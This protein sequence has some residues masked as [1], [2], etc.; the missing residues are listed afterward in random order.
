MLLVR[1]RNGY[2]ASVF[3]PNITLDLTAPTATLRA[4]Y[5]AFS[6]NNDGSQDEM[7]FTQTGSDEAIWL[8]EVRRAG[9][10]NEAVR[11]IRMSGQPPARFSWDGLTDSGAIAP[12]G[13]YTYQLSAT[14]QAGNTG[15]SAAIAFSLSTADTPVLLTTDSRAFSP[16]GDGVKDS[17]AIIPQLQ[18]NRDI[19]SWKV[20]VLDSAGNSVRTFE[21]QNSVPASLAW[22]GRTNTNTAA[23]DGTYTA[24]I[25][26]R[27]AAGN[28]PSASSRP[29]VLDTA[30]PR[31]EL[32][33]PYTLFSPNGDGK[34]DTLPINLVTE[35][36]D[37]WDAV[38]TDAQGR[39]VQSRNWT[40]AAPALSWDG[41]DQAGN[42]VPDGIYRLTLSS[43]DEAGNS[44]RKTID[45]ITVDARIPR[46]FLTVSAAGISPK[47]D[48]NIR[49][50][51]VVSLKEG[52][53]SW[54]LELTDDAGAVFRTL[55][56]SAASPDAPPET[57][58]W[59]GLDAAGRIVEGRYTPVL[60]V[61]YTKGDEVTASAAPV[62]VD[63]SGPVLSFRSEP[64]F[65]SPD[66]DGVDDELYMFLG[67]QDVSPI[68]SWSL[69]IR[70]PEPPY[71]L[72][73]RIEGRGAPT[74]RAIWDGRSSR[75]ELV[76]SATDYPFTLQAEDA[77]G[78]S[79]TLEGSIGVDVLVIRD[80]D[81]LKIQI[82]SIVFR[83]NQADFMGR[84]R[85]PVQGL[86]QAQIDNNNRILRR[87]AQILNKFRDYRIQVEGHANPTSRNPPPA[88]AAGDL[89][90][91]RRR[92]SFTVDTLVGFGVSRSRLSSTGLG[93]TRPIVQFDDHDNWWKNRR[94]EFI[95]IK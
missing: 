22:N 58:P 52:I 8:G 14:D 19:S 33:S 44:L 94:V 10:P 4:E 67:A 80:G 49:I 87:I 6:P 23:G 57:I 3:S 95:L 42:S 26:V 43:A 15:R 77:L 78:N 24:R 56:E 64:E 91:S 37:T 38:I 27:Y 84:D 48:Q 89:D 47:A 93:S 59:D 30:P 18:V 1:Y 40:G 51:T 71:L 13:N 66:N 45:T 53:E 62:L 65:F 82:P 21:G 12:D 34:R 63:A 79:S 61:I 54:K 2:E 36:N 28:Q 69:G 73:Y 11:T 55:G 92:A 81:H 50:G 41:T 46:V 25:E 17:I 7:N 39:V 32:A 16:N 60:T 86:T 31:A 29:F 85:D 20:E 5:L 88:E 35:G 74:E 70:E 72:F 9:E 75:G 90:L 83:A 76:Q 68:A